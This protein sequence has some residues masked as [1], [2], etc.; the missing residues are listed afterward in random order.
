METNNVTVES[1][2]GHSRPREDLRQ[3][4]LSEIKV[5]SE[6]MGDLDKKRNELSFKKDMFAQFIED[7]E[8]VKL[9]EITV[10][11][12]SERRY[13]IPGAYDCLKNAGKPMHF[14]EIIKAMGQDVTDESKA[15]MYHSL[16][17]KSTEN[18]LFKFEGKGMF[19][20]L[21]ETEIPSVE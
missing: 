2:N 7:L 12:K 10:I 1:K 15:S 8:G 9:P 14:T 19:S 18:K 16:R 21:E 3:K 5:I 11:R 6:K 13:N 17:R 20:I 4:Y